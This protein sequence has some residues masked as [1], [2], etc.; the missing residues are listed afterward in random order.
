M[1]D[2]TR[3]YSADLIGLHRKKD[4]ATRFAVAE[5][6]YRKSEKSKGDNLMYAFAE[7]LRNLA[8]HLQG[9]D[10]LRAGWSEYIQTL[11]TCPEQ[12]GPWKEYIK[13][14]TEE[15]LYV[16]GSGNPF[17]DI[18]SNTSS[19]LIIGNHEWG[20]A[21]TE[22]MNLLPRNPIKLNGWKISTAV[23]STTAATS[24]SKPHML[25]PL[26]KLK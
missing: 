24:S 11:K 15:E 1:E 14:F 19:L 26:K 3:N 13:H 9:L 17:K 12:K 7:G 23:Y 8:L 5:L 18:S 20:V 21:Q 22:L 4:T 2:K 16:W 6:K 10:R 25:L